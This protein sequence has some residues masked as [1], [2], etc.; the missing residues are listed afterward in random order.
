M[1]IG[2]GTD[3]IE[4]ERVKRAVERTHFRNRVFT[5]LEQN[6]CESRN[7]SKFASYAARFAG[8][9]AFF[10][11]VGTGIVTDLTDVE[12]VN[13]KSG[14]PFIRLYDQAARLV[15]PDAKIHLSLSHSKTYATAVCIIEI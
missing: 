15:S 10:K 11:A 4:I 12:I 7:N 3:I 1:I 5:P 14:Q 9:E 6:Y 8:K 2:I 13:V